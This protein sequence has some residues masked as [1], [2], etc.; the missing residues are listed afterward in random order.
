MKASIGVIKTEV[1]HV[2]VHAGVTEEGSDFGEVLTMDLTADVA[3]N[4]DREALVK[5]EALPVAACDLVAGPRVGHLVSGNIDLRLISSNN[6]WR[7]KCKQWVFHSSEWERW[8][9][10]QDGV[11]TPNVRSKILLSLIKQ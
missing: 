1:L 9:Q 2:L 11:V 10:D 4:K 7:S 5:E 8:W 3:L 6:G